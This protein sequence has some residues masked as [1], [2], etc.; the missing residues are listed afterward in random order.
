MR[1]AV[2]YGPPRAPMG[3][4]MGGPRAPCRGWI[5]KTAAP[6]ARAWSARSNFCFNLR[7]QY[8]TST[9]MGSHGEGVGPPGGE[10]QKLLCAQQFLLQLP[11]PRPPNYIQKWICLSNPIQNT[12][13]NEISIEIYSKHT[14]KLFFSNCNENTS[15]YTNLI[16]S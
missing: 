11:Q 13:E 6:A 14:P 4:G 7:S 2:A 12:Y 16:N 10:S 9:P 15:Q 5:A 1:K 3:G 8:P